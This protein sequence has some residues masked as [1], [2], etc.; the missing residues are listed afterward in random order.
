MSLTRINQFTA[1]PEHADDL[2]TFLKGLKEYITASQGCEGCEVLQHKTMPEQ[3][4]V[5]ERW[6]SADDHKAS[7]DAFAKDDMNAAVELLAAPP[8][9][10]FYH[11]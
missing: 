2:F 6:A 8:T 9:G 7:V 1:K 10:A 4:V 5:I 11:N 3:C